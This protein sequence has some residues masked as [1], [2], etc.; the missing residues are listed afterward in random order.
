M[1]IGFDPNKSEKNSRERGLPFERAADLDWDRAVTFEDV[2]ADYGETRMVTLAPLKGRLHVV[3]YS[4][5]GK[6]R[7]I[8]SFR[9]ANAREVKVYEEIF[10]R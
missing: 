4:Q 5:R 3:C 1:E 2:R 8:I 10:D 7:W 9:K 6:V